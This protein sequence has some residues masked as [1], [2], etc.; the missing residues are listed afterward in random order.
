V[1]RRRG[2]ELLLVALGVVLRWR[3]ERIGPLAVW[4]LWRRSGWTR[5]LAVLLLLSLAPV[6]L[7]TL[8]CRFSA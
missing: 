7:Y 8:W 5:P 6:G 3:V 4:W 2:P 1:V